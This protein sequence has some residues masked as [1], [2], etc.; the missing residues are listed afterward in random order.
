M[1]EYH[2]KSLDSGRHSFVHLF[3][4]FVITIFGGFIIYQRPLESVV[5]ECFG[6]G[7]I[8]LISGLISGLYGSSRITSLVMILNFVVA[9]WLN[10]TIGINLIREKENISKIRKTGINAFGFWSILASF[11]LASIEIYLGIASFTVRST[12]LD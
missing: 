2:L 1:N 4:G 12:I 10:V 5:Y 8:F 7:I 11:I 3:C 6:T 9:I